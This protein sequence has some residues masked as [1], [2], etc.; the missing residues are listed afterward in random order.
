MLE[1]RVKHI[2]QQ[3]TLEFVGEFEVHTSLS[4]DISKGNLRVIT[5]STNL[6]R[7]SIVLDKNDDDSFCARFI[8]DNVGEISENKTK[9]VL[10]S[11]LLDLNDA[12]LKV[13]V[14]QEEEDA[15]CSGTI[16][17]DDQLNPLLYEPFESIKE[18]TI[19]NQAPAFTMPL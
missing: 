13:R 1:P 17:V 16:I 3:Y 18:F 10:E 14:N 11:N 4:A 5:K 12:F 9:L 7:A 6:L 19:Q 15:N 2:L 8:D